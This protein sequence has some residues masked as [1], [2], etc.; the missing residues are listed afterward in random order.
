MPG[1]T[2]PGAACAGQPSPAE[3]IAQGA[4]VFVNQ[5]GGKDRQLMLIHLV[6]ELQLPAVS[7]SSFMPT[8]VKPNGNEQPNTR[9]LMPLGASKKTRRFSRRSC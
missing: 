6:H 9:P 8:S 4:L 5:S 7:S 2:T 1:I 3:M